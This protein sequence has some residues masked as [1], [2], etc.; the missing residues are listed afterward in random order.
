[1]RK[2]ILQVL[3]A[4]YIKHVKL[5]NQHFMALIDTA[6]SDIFKSFGEN[7]TLELCGNIYAELKVGDVKIE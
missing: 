2:I 6:S 4:K 7:N 5:D 3:A 1:M